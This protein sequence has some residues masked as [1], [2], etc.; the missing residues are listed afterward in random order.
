MAILSDR[1]I[2]GALERGI[3]TLEPFVQSRLGPAS[4]DVLVGDIY[5][6]D[7]ETGNTEPIK[8]RV[9]GNG[10]YFADSIENISIDRDN[11]DAGVTTRSSPA[12]CGLKVESFVGSEFHNYA[13]NR[14]KKFGL[15]NLPHDQRKLPVILS[16]CGTRVELPADYPPC[17]LVIAEKGTYK[18]PLSV[19]ELKEAIRKGGVRVTDNSGRTVMPFHH[20]GYS[21]YDS[22]PEE[23]PHGEFHLSFVDDVRV[24]TGKG[25]ISP[26]FDTSDV[27][28]SLHLGEEFDLGPGHF[29][30]SQTSE[31]VT[32][33]NRYVGLLTN[34]DMPYQVGVHANAP[35]IWP[36][37][38]G[39][40]IFELWSL[41]S[42]PLLE[43]L[44]KEGMRSHISRENAC[45]LLVYPLTEE[46]EHS[47]GTR[48]KDKY[49]GQSSIGYKGHLDFS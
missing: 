42:I 27:F 19:S 9:I 7:L 23:S 17:Q 4:V 29:Y 12:R 31:R 38:D 37:S 20:R 25:V 3:F 5:R 16:T 15:G 47:Y 33:G 24:Y 34:R 28:A 30:L 2:R 1:S 35:F 43:I 45:H 39:S 6:I 18:R 48:P 22:F 46:P 21:Q 40:Q 41:F 14:M 8:D 36:G 26:R 49:R 11:F 44:G 13:V 32:L 10:Y